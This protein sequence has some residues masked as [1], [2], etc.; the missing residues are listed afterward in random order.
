MLD[1][2]RK[3]LNHHRFNLVKTW[4]VLVVDGGCVG[5]LQLLVLAP[6]HPMFK[7]TAVGV[8]MKMKMKLVELKPEHQ[9]RKRRS[10][11]SGKHK[12]K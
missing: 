12:D 2:G 5:D 4:H 1:H 7:K 6:L 11:K 3:L 10:D 8:K 9:R